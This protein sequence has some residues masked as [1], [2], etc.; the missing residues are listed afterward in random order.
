M[1]KGKPVRACVFPGGL[2]C[3]RLCFVLRQSILPPKDGVDSAPSPEHHNQGIKV[4]GGA[5][6]FPP[7]SDFFDPC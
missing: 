6:L 4:R 2:L 5:F 7:T 1:T 3:V